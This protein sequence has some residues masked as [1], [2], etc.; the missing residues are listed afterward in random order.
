MQTHAHLQAHHKERILVLSID[1]DRCLFNDQYYTL[2]SDSKVLE[3]NQTL[4]DE[5]VK[6]VETNNYD[7]V[8][9]MAGSNRQSK[10]IDDA[11]SE[12][13]GSDSYFEALTTLTQ[14]V[15]NKLHVSCELD[16]F[17]LSDLY[18]DRPF[19]ENFTNSLNKNPNYQFGDYIWDD[20]KISLLY[21]QFHKIASE[22]PQANIDFN[23]I[24]DRMD[25]IEG[26]SLFYTRNQLLI[27]HNLDLTLNHYEGS[28]VSPIENSTLKSTSL[29]KTGI[30]DYHFVENIKL[31]A[32]CCGF[33]MKNMLESQPN[34]SIS[35]RLTGDV[36]KVFINK[37]IM[38][39]SD[40]SCEL[41]NEIN[42]L[43]DAK[44]FTHEVAFH[45]LLSTAKRLLHVFKNMIEERNKNEVLHQEL[46][47][48]STF[49][50]LKE[51][52][53]LLREVASKEFYTDDLSC[54]RITHAIKKLNNTHN[55][56]TNPKI[57]LHHMSQFLFNLFPQT[58]RVRKLTQ[59]FT[60]RLQNFIDVEK[61]LYSHSNANIR[62][63]RHH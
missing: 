19:G 50:I 34:N 24:D 59:E 2:Q 14:A 1:G 4:I 3:A 52:L 15:K 30:I 51:T 60:E 46:S 61:K 32:Q 7:R 17:L 20:D 21:A 6:K 25:I 29:T 48:Q 9:F 55:Q 45:G 5:I 18:S 43:H 41:E 27:P 49:Q 63:A 16:Q 33:S 10:S 57:A 13:N 39:L 31:M 37:R 42:K 47:S 44:P 28:T 54:E 26:L 22:N 36:E 53:F 11:N 8:I 35:Q 38:S 23:F 40:L 56:L 62:F 58:N 12:H